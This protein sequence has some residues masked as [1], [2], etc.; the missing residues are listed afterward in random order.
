MAQTPQATALVWEEEELSYEELNARANQLA[1][2]LAAQG[3]GAESIVGLLLPRGADCRARERERGSDT[4]AHTP[5]DAE[6]E[7]VP[8]LAERARALGLTT[9]D[10]VCPLV[11]KVH[12]EAILHHR[13]LA[14]LFE[15]AHERKL[16]NRA[17]HLNA[18]LDVTNR[19][20]ILGDFRAITRVELPPLRRRPCP[21]AW[22]SGGRGS[23]S[24]PP[25]VLRGR[26][27]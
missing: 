14:L 13:L 1:H 25:P 18:P 27:G 22:R 4:A 21:T 2:Y 16:G 7:L 10:A 24:R 23:G 11:A 6:A 12:K 26:C 15:R 20:E 19:I 9:Y 8:A 17:R 5:A 3:V